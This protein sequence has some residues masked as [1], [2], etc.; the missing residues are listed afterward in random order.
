MSVAQQMLHENLPLAS[1]T[2]VNPAILIGVAAVAA[3]VLNV[4]K[5]T[6]HWHHT[7]NAGELGVWLAS[8]EPVL[9]N[10]FDEAQ[11]ATI[12]PGSVEDT[13]AHYKIVGPKW[14]F[15]PP[16]RTLQ[17]VYVT[18][19]P[20]TLLLQIDSA[21]KDKQKLDIDAKITWNV[22]PEG[23]NPVRSIMNVKHIKTD[24]KD[25]EAGEKA[26]DQ[27]DVPLTERVIAVCSAGLGR[28][29]SN[30]KADYLQQLTSLGENDTE[31]A[32]YD[33]L[34]ET[35]QRQTIEQCAR[36]LINYGVVLSAVELIP[37]VR[38]DAEVQAQALRAMQLPLEPTLLNGNGDH[39][40]GN[41]NGHAV[42]VSAA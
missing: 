14:Y 35:V 1:I 32:Q 11:V 22:S 21:D 10:G 30:R 27:E 23:D 41:G 17:T 18:D 33:A 7:I 15:V 19:R 28:V 40:N 6:P 16:F 5:M 8:G 26:N 25:A 38:S 13:E 31:T 36:R 20:G 39:H 9:K 37:V 12:E 24:K 34:R 2:D 29:L 4:K 42:V 3:G